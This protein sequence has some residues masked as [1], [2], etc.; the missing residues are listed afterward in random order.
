MELTHAVGIHYL[1]ITKPKVAD[2]GEYT[3]QGTS[4]F[5]ENIRVAS[6]TFS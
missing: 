5:S 2:I 6:K 3:C 1:K 4:K